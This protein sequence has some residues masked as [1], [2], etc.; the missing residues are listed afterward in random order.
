MIK[1]TSKNKHFMDVYYHAMSDLACHNP[2]LSH[3]GNWLGLTLTKWML[4][5]INRIKFNPAWHLPQMLVVSVACLIN[6]L[7]CAFFG[8]RRGT[9]GATG[10][11]AVFSLKSDKTS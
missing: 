10:V 8:P 4:D 3:I 2:H 9:P 6:N 1:L 7:S 11:L 5:A